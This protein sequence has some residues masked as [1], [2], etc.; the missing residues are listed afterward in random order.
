MPF[1]S[2]AHLLFLTDALN[3]PDH[4]MACFC[5]IKAQIDPSF[6]EGR[7]LRVS[8]NKSWFS[9]VAWCFSLPQFT[10]GKQNMPWDAE[11]GFSFLLQ[12]KGRKMA[13]MQPFAESSGMDSDPDAD[14]G[15]GE[16]VNHA[17]SRKY[18]VVL[19]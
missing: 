2:T 12:S 18:N 3:K 8:T 10:I 15:Y 17:Q 4:S 9:Y 16:I 5:K 7:V 11:E 19:R 14:I 6:L 13:L 1:I